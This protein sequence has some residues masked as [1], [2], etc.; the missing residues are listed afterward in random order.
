MLPPHEQLQKD[1]WAQGD[2]PVR[3]DSL[4][5]YFVDGRIAMFS[6][7]LH[8]LR[9]RSYIYLAN[10]GITPGLELIRGTDHRAGPDGSPE[11]DT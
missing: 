7:C 8:F 6:L 9:A 11:P 10:W 1:W 5:T 4:V 3:N 2:T